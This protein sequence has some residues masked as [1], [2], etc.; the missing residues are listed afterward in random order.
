MAEPTAENQQQT[1]NILLRIA[2]ANKEFTMPQ[3]QIA[4]S[5]RELVA[6]NY[7]A[8][9]RDQERAKKEEAQEGKQRGF[10]ATMLDYFGWSRKEQERAAKTAN[11]ESSKI[12]EFAKGFV[13]KINTAAK[14]IFE[15]LLSGLGL[16]A[17]GKLLN[18][19]ANLDWDKQLEQW[20]TWTDAFI[21]GISGIGA[22]IGFRKLFTAIGEVFGK[23]GKFERFGNTVRKFFDNRFFKSIRN[24]FFGR[25]GIFS[26]QTRVIRPILRIMRTAFKNSGGIIDG[27]RKIREIFTKVLGAFGK[28]GKVGKVFGQILGFLGKIPGVQKALNFLKTIGKV[29]SRIFFPITMLMAA[30]EAITGGLDEAAAESGSIPQKILSFLSGALKGLLDFF[31]FDLADLIQTGVKKLIEWFMGLFGFSEDEI[32]AATDFDIVKSVRDSVFKAIDFV[33]DL[34]R[35]PEEGLFSE[36]GMAKLVDILLLPLNLAI[37][38]IRDLFGWNEPE[39][40]FS[41]GTF[42]VEKFNAAKDWLVSFFT[43][44]KEN[45][46]VSWIETTIDNVITTVKDWFNSLFAWGKGV[47][48]ETGSF[49]DTTIDT[50]VTTVKGWLSSLFSWSTTEDESDSYVV[51]LLKD[52]VNGAKKWLSSMFKFDST[53]DILASAFNAMTFLPNIVYKGLTAVSSWL[54]GLFGFDDAAKSIANAG[55]FSLGDLVMKAVDAIVEWLSAL[56]NFDIGG[57]FKEKMGKLGEIGSSL[58]ESVGNLF[59]GGDEVKERYMGGPLQSGDYSLVGERG[60]ELIKMGSPGMVI[61]AKESAQMM[62]GG[63]AAMVNAPTTNNV[64]NPTTT[65]ILMPAMSTDPKRASLG[66]G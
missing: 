17:L 50:V 37:N 16:V 25:F 41:L 4:I 15:L 24:I 22:F 62:G 9:K 42:I 31:I 46:A 54:A 5:N 43:W 39:E 30:Y 47:A 64:T 6:Q 57:F 18:Y 21:T 56:L 51:T 27:F 33:R 10:W 52:A 36:E 40:S 34:F 58:L 44:N 28:E 60:P 20:K 8:A 48:S 29:F 38:F 19:L 49:I 13:D 55:E 1:N 59:G 32:K 61:P 11:R 45:A 35:F 26:L 3:Q 53:S 14:G 7:E 2:E 65:N 63:G 66:L 23:G 12:G